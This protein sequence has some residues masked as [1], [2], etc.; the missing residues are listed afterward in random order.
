[1]IKTKTP[2]KV[3]RRVVRTRTQLAASLLALMQE[4][5]FDDITIKDI[6][7]RA[8]MNR[9]TF[10]LHYGTKEELLFTSLESRFDQLVQSIESG[11]INTPENPIWSDDTYDRLVFEHVAEHVDLYKVILDQ[12]GMGV[13]IHRIIDYIAAVGLRT[14]LESVDPN[15]KVEIPHEIVSRHV[16]GSMFA[17]IVWWVRNDL[18]YSA[19]EMAKMCHQLV[20][21]GCA[22]TLSDSK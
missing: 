16:A 22:P 8:D 4:K 13:I 9:A 6:T 7:D 14:T 18:P 11:L 17:M 15:A 1:M 2:R 20:S 21:Y 19:A 5:N 12:N 10:Y 3:D